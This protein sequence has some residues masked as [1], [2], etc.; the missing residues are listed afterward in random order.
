MAKP[1]EATP[2]LK[3]QDLFNFAKSL[4]KKD[5]LRSQEKRKSALSMLRKASSSR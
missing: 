1:I 4:S 5:T 3:G 2:I